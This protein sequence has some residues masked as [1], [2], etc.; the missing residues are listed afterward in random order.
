MRILVIGSGGM[1]GHM[2]T[3]YLAEQ[4]YEVW[5]I[6]KTKRCRKETALLDV[7][8]M[9]V[10]SEYLNQHSFDVVINC[11]A[12]LVRACEVNPEMAEMLNAKFPHWLEEFFERTPTRIIQVSTAGVFH[13][14][15]APYSEMDRCDANGC[16]NDTKRRGEL[17]NKKDL[18]VRSDFW[19]PDMSDGAS[20]IFH[21]IMT[22][23]GAVTGFSNVVINGVSSLEFARFI[24][25]VIRF[26]M[27]GIYHLYSEESISK[28]DLL[29]KIC[30]TFGRIDIQVSDVSEP[31]RNTSLETVR[32]YTT[33]HR[34][35]YEKQLDELKEWIKNHRELYPHYD[36]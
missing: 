1:L 16:Y 3:L 21:W 5:D 24:E 30:E 7:C 2:T 11:A 15:Y 27:T 36:L 13:G 9:V 34:K 17:N 6:S 22:E 33:Y 10:M 35:G 4:G 18:T 29:R 14:D 12:L 20:G 8:D 28:A 25:G 31:R 26:P 23:K 32:E 19:G